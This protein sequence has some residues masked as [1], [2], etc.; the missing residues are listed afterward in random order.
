MVRSSPPVLSRHASSSRLPI[1][2]IVAVGLSTV[3]SRYARDRPRSG[4]YLLHA[5]GWTTRRD[6]ARCLGPKAESKKRKTT[7]PRV[8]RVFKMVYFMDP[9]H[10]NLK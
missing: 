5:F 2:P 8:L 1:L 10:G 6:V 7:S 9:R 4:R 3:V